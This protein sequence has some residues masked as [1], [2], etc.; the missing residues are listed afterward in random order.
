M[1]TGLLLHTLLG[2]LL[3]LIPAGALYVL[4]RKKLQS[5]V[6][7]VS[8][9]V[10]QLLVLCLIVW[11]LIKVDNAWLSLAWLLVM[12]GISA[13]IVLKRCKL[14]IRK[15]MLPTSAGLFM[16]VFLIGLWL[17][18]LVLPVR[19]FNPRWFV[20]VMA[21]LLGH[22]TS[23]MIRGL[24]TYVSALHTDQQ[25][26]EFLR[27]NGLTHFKALL[28]FFRQSLLAILSPTIANLTTLG[29]TTMPLLLCGLFLG[30]MT[31]INAFFAMLHMTVGCIAVS[32]VALAITL[33]L[34]DKALFGK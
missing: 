4:E 21:L 19:I 25:Q 13:F 15:L 33:F 17:L 18:G 27:G 3:L 28:P 10:T 8:R 12:S 20:P 22:A 24:S 16:G 5:F 1:N 23:M 11:G 6:V 29:L 7:A 2:L 32:V 31:P 30:G 9:M 14:D 26:Y 34:A